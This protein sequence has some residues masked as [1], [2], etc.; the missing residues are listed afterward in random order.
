MTSLGGRPLKVLMVTPR[1]PPDLGGT[2]RHVYEVSRRL[3]AVG[4]EMSVLCTDRSGQRT[5]IEV[6]DG[7]RVERVRAWP[8]RRDYYL[9]P[10]LWRAMAREDCDLVHVQSY[11]T[12]VAPLAMARAITLGVPFVVTFHGGGHSSVVRHRLRP[13]QRRV[14]R[15]LLRR[16][17]RLVAVARF[18]INLYGQELRLPPG[19]FAL[20]P[21]GVETPSGKA[22]AREPVVATIG[23][24]ERYKGQERVL[25]AF[26]LVLGSRPDVGLWIVGDGPQEKALRQRAAALGVAE[27]VEFIR[28]P[29]DEPYAMASLL[30]RVGLAVSLSE[31]E[32]HPLTALEAVASGTVPLV[33][34]TSGLH[35]LAE[36]GL[37]SAIPLGSSREEIAQ[38]I[39]Q[40]LD[41]KEP[42]PAARLP[43][44]D[45]CASQLLELYRDV[46]CGS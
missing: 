5:G 7:V 41:S 23:R 20:I 26:P 21:N 34:D 15:P 30:A 35:E 31:F 32:T 6:H 36:D 2:E 39:L 37:A 33:A 28:V 38:A 10:G 13:V 14:L 8:A 24:L 40:R 12:A 9:A 44:W 45:D 18:E 27:R 16:A 11:H 17:A 46:L 4:C 19:R 22:V 29:S 1:F 3:A 25:E 42:A 43:T